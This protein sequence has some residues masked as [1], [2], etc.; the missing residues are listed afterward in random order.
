MLHWLREAT[1]AVTP[2]MVPSRYLFNPQSNQGAQYSLQGSFNLTGQISGT[3]T[4]SLNLNLS[5]QGGFG[6]YSFSNMNSSSLGTNFA[7]QGMMRFFGFNWPV[8][9]FP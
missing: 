7:P 2:G 8:F 5:G 6:G 3:S 9:S 1:L 4:P